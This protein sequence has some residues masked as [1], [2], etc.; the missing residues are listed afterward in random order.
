ME[1][2]IEDYLHFHIGCFVIYVGMKN[3]RKL[4]AS[5]LGALLKNNACKN[6]KPILRRVSD[7]T[8][9]EAMDLIRLN[10]DKSEIINIETQ[11]ETLIIFSRKHPKMRHTVLSCIKLNECSPAEF[12]WLLS[13]HFDIFRLI[14]AGIAIDK[15]AI[16]EPKVQVSDTTMLNQGTK[17]Q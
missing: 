1:K 5:W 11:N 12:L 13:K 8:K 15:N 4:T 3:W 17:S 10:V 9:D 2:K 16:T 7:M 6:I 14:D